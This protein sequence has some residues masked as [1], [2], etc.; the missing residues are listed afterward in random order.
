MNKPTF[1][2]KLTLQLK[3]HPI[4]S[5][6]VTVAGIALVIGILFFSG[7]FTSERWNYLPNR[8]YILESEAKEPQNLYELL[9]SDNPSVDTLL[10]NPSI[11]DEI[12]NAELLIDIVDG[13][14]AL[15]SLRELDR[16]ITERFEESVEKYALIDLPVDEES[17]PPDS[18]TTKPQGA[19]DAHILQTEALEE[20]NDAMGRL[21]VPTWFGDSVQIDSTVNMKGIWQNGEALIHMTP[22]G[23]WLPDNGYDLYRVINGEKTLVQ[24]G[25]AS[26]KPILEGTGTP[27]MVPFTDEEGNLFDENIKEIFEIASLTDTKLSELGLT[28][29]QFRQAYYVTN[30]LTPIPRISG[31]ADFEI[32]KNLQRTIPG[33]IEQKIPE[34]DLLIDQP[35]SVMGRWPNGL[36]TSASIHES[37]LQKFSVTQVMTLKIDALQGKSDLVRDILDARQ[38]LTAMSFADK[39]FAEAANFLIHDDLS[40]LNLSDGTVITY[41]AEIPGSGTSATLKITI[42]VEFKLSKPLGLDGYGADGRVPLRWSEAETLEERSILIG[43]NIERR[44]DGES[45][46]TQIN[47]VPVAITHMLDDSG[48]YMG[49]AIIYE[50]EVANGRAAQYRIC[51]LDIFGRKSE[52]SD[53]LTINEEST[54]KVEKVTPPNAPSIQAPILSTDDSGVKAKAVETAISQN[55]GKKGIVLPIHTESP[56]TARFTIYRAVA[57]GA[58][59]FG[60]PEILADIKYESQM[61]DTTTDTQGSS[62]YKITK[63]RGAKHLAFLTPLPAEP[64]LVWFDSDITEGCTYKYWVS[65]WDDPEWNNESA[66]SASATIGVS[67]GAQPKTPD[68]LTINMLVKELPEL[69]AL[70]P[71]IMADS[72]ITK[73]ALTLSMLQDLPARQYNTNVNIETAKKAE[74]DKVIIGQFVSGISEAFVAPVISL[75]YDNLPT[76]KYIHAFIA[77]RGEDVKPDGSAYIKWQAY[78]NEGLKGYVVYKSEF[79]DTQSSLEEMQKMTPKELVE[80]CKWRKVGDTITQN[81]VCVSGLD[82]TS[83][84]L[85]LFLVCLK[86]EFNPDSNIFIAES[87][88]TKDS[89]EVLTKPIKPMVPQVPLL[90][91]IKL[92]V[93]GTVTINITGTTTV[94][95]DDGQKWSI[96]TGSLPGEEHTYSCLHIALLA[97]KIDLQSSEALRPYYEVLEAY[98]NAYEALFNAY[99]EYKAAYDDLLADYEE[100][101]VAYEEAVYQQLISGHV[102]INWE[103]PDDPQIKYYR[104]Y[105]SEV[106]KWEFQRGADLTQMEWM[107]V[108][109]KVTASQFTDPVEQ[110]IA[111]YYYYK[112]TAVSAWGVE[113][114][115]GT[116]Q[117]F[118]IP[119]TVP[120][121]I[122]AM[123]MPLSSKNG[124]MVNF[125]AVAGC[126]KYVLYRVEIPKLT[127][128]QHAELVSENK[129]VFDALF[130]AT[131]ENNMVISDAIKNAFNLT[132]VQT[133]D[134]NVINSFKTVQQINIPDI[135]NNLSSVSNNEL[136]DFTKK[137][138]D[139]YGPLII[140]DYTDLSLGMMKL[141][142]WEEVGVLPVLE[143]TKESSEGNNIGLLQPLFIEDNT[144]EFGHKYLYTVR[145]WNDD[146][147]GSAASEPVEG[148]PRRNGPFDP[149]GGVKAIIENARPSITWNPPKMVKAGLTVEECIRDSVGYIVYRADTEEGPYYQASPLL[150][151]TGWV[152]N[153][154]DIFASNWYSVRVLDIGGYLSDFSDPV[155]VSAK[156]TFSLRP[157][158]AFVSNHFNILSGSPFQTEYILMGSTPITVTLDAIGPNGETIS[159]FS[160]NTATRTVT[161]P[162]TL[163]T[164]LYTVIVTA[165]N[166]VGETSKSFTLEVTEEEPVATPPELTLE[167]TKFIIEQ[168][169]PFQTEYTLTGSEPITVTVEATGPD[170]GIISGFSINHTARTVNAPRTLPAGSFFNVTVTAKNSAG[171]SSKSFTLEVKAAAPVATPPKLSLEAERFVVKQGTPFQTSYSLTGSEPITVT[172]KATGPDGESIRG[173]SVNTAAQ[174]IN[175]NTADLS[176]KSYNVTVTAKNS[177]GESSKS[178][179]LFVTEAPQLIPP[180]LEAREDDYSFSMFRTLDFSTKLFASGSEPLFWS[181]EPISSRM[182]V[183]A[184]ANI[185][186]TGLLSITKGIPTG[187]YSFYVKVEN[188]SGFDKKE[189]T[190]RV[191]RLIIPD[192]RGLSVDSGQKTVRLTAANPQITT[193]QIPIEPEV[194]VPV[195]NQYK[196][197]QLVCMHFSLSDVKLSQAQGPLGW[198]IGYSGTA[199]LDI[200]YDERIPV[201]ITGAHIDLADG[202]GI[203]RMVKGIV[204]I[205]DP[206]TLDKCG[207]T[208]TNLELS[209]ESEKAVAD[210]YM[211]STIEDQNLVGNIGVLE[212]KDALIY[213]GYIE[214]HGDNLPDIRYAQFTFSPIVM[215]LYMSNQKLSNNELISMGC[216]QVLLKSHLETLDNTDIILMPVG[217]DVPNQ[218]K[219][220][221]EGKITAGKIATHTNQEEQ[222]LQLLVPGG[223]MLRISQAS[224]SFKDGGV[225]PMGG[226]LR[227][228]LILPFEASGGIS[229]DGGVEG[230]YAAP[231]H[232]EEGDLD[233]LLKAADGNLPASL[234]KQMQDGVIHFGETVQSQGLLIVPQNKQKQ[235][236]CS[237][238]KISVNNWTG[239]G[240]I[241]ENGT[242]MTNTNMADRSL[243]LALQHKQ[244]FEIDP[245]GNVTVDLSRTS[246]FNKPG[247]PKECSE[248]FWVGIIINDGKLLLPPGYLQTE[249]GSAIEFNLAPGKMIYDLNGFNY[250]TYLYAPTEEG[251]KARTGEELGGFKDAWIHDVMVDMYNNKIDFEV[252]LT[253]AVDFLMGNMVDAKLYTLKEPDEY[254]NKP[255]TFLCSVTP[256]L[257][258][259]SVAENFDLRIDSGWFEPQGMRISGAMQLPD[260]DLGFD[261][262]SDDLLEFI[263]LVIPAEKNNTT[264]ST[265]YG[266]ATL[267]EPVKV[268]FNGFTVEVRELNLEYD[269][270]DPIFRPNPLGLLTLYNSNRITLQGATVLSDNIPL[271]AE[272]TDSIVITSRRADTPFSAPALPFQLRVNYDTSTSVLNNTFD[273]CFTVGGVLTPKKSKTGSASASHTGSGGQFRTLAT[274]DGDRFMEY[275]TADLAFGFL[276]SLGVIPF[277][278]DTRFGFDTVLSRNYFAIRLIYDGMPVEFGVGQISNV[279]GIVAYN[280][281]IDRD[282]KQHNRFIFP[283]NV[284]DLEV[285]TGSGTSFAAAIRGTL[286]VMHLCEIREMYFAFDRGPIVEA[287]GDFYVPLDPGALL[288]SNPDPFTKVGTVVIMY[289][290]PNRHF[291]F[292]TDLNYKV[293]SISV[294]GSISLQYNPKLFGVYIG[295][296]EMLKAHIPPYKAGAGFGFQ[297]ASEDSFVAAK[298]MLGW[299]YDADIGIVYISGYIEGGASG[300][301]HFK[302][303]EEGSFN[304]DIYVT[305]GIKGGIRFRGRHDIISLY[306]NAEGSLSKK[307]TGSWRLSASCKVGYSLDLFLV[308]VSGSVSA[309]FS[310][311]F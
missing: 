180:K 164:G 57:V 195:T 83:G 45:E 109:D 265:K 175:A 143:D 91:S 14:F 94:I 277:K 228:R 300:E 152:D 88:A 287:G 61:T 95:L 56:D 48:Y 304:L 151:N 212:F 193:P 135:R 226:I 145:A 256:T 81:Q 136:L 207:V 37:I 118:R 132:N 134:I 31:A 253:V 200:G 41:M 210:G 222:A 251:V 22:S 64:N 80:M 291:T 306:V 194:E 98:F 92:N 13:R 235:D 146:G 264:S 66:W 272:N 49:S 87:T 269:T 278:T 224:L 158:I 111:H 191:I 36:Y 307:S 120:P 188:S 78:S 275:E 290:H 142:T 244:G 257:I 176:P 119:A 47:D 268:N 23:D 96:K 247:A 171:E 295:Y 285:Y 86:P 39:D 178:F 310:M 204:Y 130:R 273:D 72:I 166:S 246:S 30:T 297:A 286:N 25:V 77:V 3:K 262:K 183:P 232:I 46:F 21:L 201:R 243:D 242:S 309:D 266:F 279:E 65:A 165:K 107:L 229:S 153:E 177:A 139:L 17:S 205:E 70:P 8:A 27:I 63:A 102:I 218:F 122:P 230:V 108:G 4:K 170:G 233:A 221:M 103:K 144:A 254:G 50:D 203:D 69:S 9:H 161:A 2:N 208:I 141:V 217:N 274:G 75:E 252:N 71:G 18:D 5:T 129:E 123:Q 162:G 267:S 32:M 241:T 29:D 239:E 298:L 76:S 19:T 220:D 154:A 302:G 60:K 289:N 245:K 190:L 301:Y 172:I 124:V 293:M 231:A 73:Q 128:S 155:Y 276:D 311:S 236:Q 259:N 284:H 189:I 89:S 16:Q 116:T 137:V 156:F 52:Y 97:I 42:G 121:A 101:M 126:D 209:P 35:I 40:A 115:V 211:Q 53:T 79:T 238:V 260:A 303:A 179:Y 149:I 214:L 138:V 168:G 58:G 296:P 100:A 74:A 105:R 85:N 174:T 117:G 33:T 90:S 186:D 51:S 198:F 237:Y 281:V 206:V 93:P 249:D 169:S 255:G 173:F 216:S 68:E 104:V 213:K 11:A 44:L 196:S 202:V 197:A 261:V 12:L 159:D 82:S 240:F 131:S 215:R 157:T 43:Y 187:T 288:K 271:S 248:D 15:N 181:L 227:G 280:M 24:S 140:S 223:S 38:H 160:I 163:A 34:V 133:G 67:S 20:L 1:M 270:G 182:T 28:A 26:P 185:D 125:S 113:S 99:T 127:D 234:L 112:V 192:I 55:S 305:G 110:S 282:T 148:T 283:K 167:R 219:F 299:Q 10:K 184:Q 292:N 7:V 106:T 54:K 308:S 150:F 62:A 263:D 225:D 258:E 250:Q 59:S 199:M 114:S 294:T 84:S 147:L 6:F